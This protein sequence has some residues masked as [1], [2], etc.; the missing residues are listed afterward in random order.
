[1]RLW[2]GLV[3]PE[4]DPFTAWPQQAAILKGARHPESANLYLN[5]LL[6]DEDAG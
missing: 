1:M 6:D 3:L 5:W 4:H 2:Y